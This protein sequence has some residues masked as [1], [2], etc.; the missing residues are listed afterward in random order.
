[1]RALISLLAIS[2]VV[3]APWPALAQGS[4]VLV[5]TS[6]SDAGEPLSRGLVERMGE[7]IGLNDVQREV[8]LELFK[9]LAEQRQALSDARREAIDRARQDAEGGDVSEFVNIMKAETVK[10]QDAVEGLERTFLQDLEALVLPEQ[11]EAWPKA[12]R[13]FRRGRYMTRLMRSEARVDVDALVR[14]RFASVYS[15]EDVAAVLERWSV[16]VDGLLQER[17]RRAEQIHGGP[18]FR[19]SIFLIDGEDHFKPLRELDARIASASHQAVRALAGAMEDSGIEDAWI[20]AAYVRVYRITDS[21]RRLEAALELDGLSDEQKEQL[22]AVA[23]Q[24]RRNADAARDRWVRAERERE[25]EDT[26]PPGMVV[27]IDGQEPTP[28][29]LA[30][31]AVAELG[32]RLEAKLRAILTPEQLAALPETSPEPEQFEFAPATGSRTIRIGG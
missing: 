7:A 1:M 16:Q 22:R 8:A 31:Q 13:I 5:T 30:K 19:G 25:A 12:E 6:A 27:R 32:E 15:R 24:H 14:D 29:D 10:Y 17:A 28:S 4:R 2:L 21:E 9:A 20:R 18:D 3:V 11:S 26:L 23:D